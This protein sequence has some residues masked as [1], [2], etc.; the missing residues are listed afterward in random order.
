M[1][2]GREN[3]HLWLFMLKYEQCLTR[4]VVTL[5]FQ[6]NTLHQQIN[7]IYNVIKFIWR[8]ILKVCSYTWV[9][10]SHE[11]C[12]LTGTQFNQSLFT[13]GY[14][15]CITEGGTCVWQV[16]V[17]LRQS[18]HY[19]TTRKATETKTVRVL[20]CFHNNSLQFCFAFTIIHYS[21]VLLSQ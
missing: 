8:T 19:N 3:L 2:N 12:S 1:E 6:F 20:L 13:P 4:V 16:Q 21:F 9:P 11:I 14:G 17:I 5:L 18:I 15:H 10:M 7:W